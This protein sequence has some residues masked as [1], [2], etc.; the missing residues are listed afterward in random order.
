M[1]SSTKCNLFFFYSYR[2]GQ[3]FILLICSSVPFLIIFRAP[4]IT[5]MVVVLRCHII[6]I[7]IIIIISILLGSS[8]QHQLV[9]FHWSRSNSKSLQ[10]SWT[11]LGFLA[12]LNNDAVWMVSILPLI[13][14]FSSFFLT[15]GDTSKHT[16]FICYHHHPNVPQLF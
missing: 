7:I 11:L 4:T 14:N 13:L 8:L 10:V 12:N 1:S 3:Q 6:I 16:N 9:V 5:G 15:F 2:L